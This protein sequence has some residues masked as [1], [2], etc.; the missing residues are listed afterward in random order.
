MNNKN[1]ETHLARTKNDKIVKSLHSA[2]DTHYK[3][4]FM[5][6]SSKTFYD[7]IIVYFLELCV[8]L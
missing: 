3:K 7:F 2:D 4:R 8:T 6:L 1:L 5:L